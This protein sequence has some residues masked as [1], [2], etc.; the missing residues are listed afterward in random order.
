MCVCVIHMCIPL[1]LPHSELQSGTLS[2]NRI[3]DGTELRL[4]PAVESGVTVSNIK[5][6]ILSPWSVLSAV[7]TMCVSVCVCIPQYSYGLV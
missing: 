7:F 4:V 2:E 1:L 3:V 5:H 6:K